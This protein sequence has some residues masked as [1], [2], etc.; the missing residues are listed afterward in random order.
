MRK[1]EA[2]ELMQFLADGYKALTDCANPDPNNIK[3][4]QACQMAVHAL[5][6]YTNCNNCIHKV[7]IEKMY[8]CDTW[9]CDYE[10]KEVDDE[11]S[12]NS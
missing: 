11:I 1:S 9:D 12:G 2:I 7:K 8:G 5:E 3:L 10:Q 4:M 6:Q